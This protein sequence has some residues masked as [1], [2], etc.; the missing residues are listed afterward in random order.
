MGERL[1]AASHLTP[2]PSP[3]AGRGKPD[4]TV[5]IPD[6]SGILN[7][8]RGDSGQGFALE[9]RFNCIHLAEGRFV[10][11]LNQFV[12]TPRLIPAN[13]TDFW[14]DQNISVRAVL[15]CND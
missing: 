5:A 3:R 14:S 10:P 13:V 11:Q 7:P 12:S 9:E 8:R 15:V 4:A 1:R 2:N 6:K